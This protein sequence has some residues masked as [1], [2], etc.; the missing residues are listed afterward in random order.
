MKTSD[1]FGTYE[2]RQR[3]IPDYESDPYRLLSNIED[4]LIHEYHFNLQ[5]VSDMSATKTVLAS[6]LQSAG[7]TATRHAY[8]TLDEWLDEKLDH[9]M[10]RANVTSSMAWVIDNTVINL[11]RAMFFRDYKAAE[12]D[13]NVSKQ[14][15]YDTFIDNFL[16]SVDNNDNAESEFKD[17]VARDLVMLLG[18]SDTMH[19][20]AGRMSM[21]VGRDYQ[22][23][24]FGDLL[25][26]DKPMATNVETRA[27][28]AQVAKFVVEDEEGTAEE[29]AKAEA[30]TLEMLLARAEAQAARSFDN[31]KR[32]NPIVEGLIEVASRYKQACEF[33]EL[34]KQLQERLII[35]ASKATERS[36]GQLATYNTID[37]M[38]FGLIMRNVRE[39]KKALNAVLETFRTPEEDATIR[40][41]QRAAKLKA[42]EQRV[43]GDKEGAALSE[44]EAAALAD[45]IANPPVAIPVAD[46]TGTI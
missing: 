37:A 26:A 34:D 22:P 46:V 21:A 35:Q 4:A 2:A 36:A 11:A 5:G 32:L 38:G 33:H 19:D 17:G 1:D 29:V 30:Q 12:H 16:G 24:T 18:Y 27:K 40:A 15:A 14:E 43:A 20:L 3:E 42:K 7:V 31:R 23:K 9:E 6:A 8:F 44:E 45:R 28:L 25:R 41:Q 10:M 13:D 39:I